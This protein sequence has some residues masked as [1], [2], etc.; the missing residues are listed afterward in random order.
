MKKLFLLA[1]VL[2][3]SACATSRGAFIVA[4]QTFAQ[5]VFALDDAEYQAFQI[6]AIS[7]AQH[8]KLNV[9]IKQALVDVK[10]VTL[11]IKQTPANGKVPVSLPDLLKDLNDV[12]NI[13]ATLQPVA[14]A[15]AQK[16]AAANNAAIVLLTQLVGGGK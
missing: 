3:M 12:Q 10:A 16:A 5:S 7:D 14:P 6:H 9:P 4:D 11:A 13:I 2:M 8:Q 15:I 1:L